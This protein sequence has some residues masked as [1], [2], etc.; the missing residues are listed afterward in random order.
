LRRREFISCMGAAAIGASLP[1]SVFTQNK[2]EKKGQN[3]I[4][5]RLYI[6]ALCYGA[7]NAK[8]IDEVIQ[9]GLT[10]AV[11]DIGIYPRVYN[12]AVKEL[13]D[14]NSL[15]KD[16]DF[17]LLPVL[18]AAHFIRARKENKLGIILACQDASILGTS[19]GNWETNL[20]LFHTLGLRVL[21]LTHNA[22]THW[23][24]SFMEKRDGGLSLAG[25]ELVAEMNELGM[26]I[27]LSHCSRQTLLDAVQKSE[28]PCAITHAG[29]KALAA[30]KRNKSD[31]EIRAIGKNGGFFGVFNMTT[32]LTSKPTANLDTVIDHIDHAVQLIGADKVGFGS[33]GALNKLNAERE[34]S[35]MANV[36]KRNAGGPSAEW[37]VRHTRVPELNAPNRL[38]VLAEGLSKRGFT[39]AQIDGIAGGNFIRLFQQ[40]CG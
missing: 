13:S 28:K 29:C 38:S 11:I 17:K 31:E 8:S 10:T 15:F 2:E 1:S 34:L 24:E 7:I 12:A 4:G 16:P 5:D 14:W 21:Q 18:K 32:W 9:G 36:Q 37:E 6:D 26:I 22:R 3:Q 39:D 35:N 30:T 27:D 25:E 40:V 33:D 23:A 20:N 19:L